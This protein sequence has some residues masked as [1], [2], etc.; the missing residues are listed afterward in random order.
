MAG[1]PADARRVRSPKA[2]LLGTYRRGSF[3]AE[4]LGLA[5]CLRLGYPVVDLPI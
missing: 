1:N 3:F 4:Q 2:L 5:P